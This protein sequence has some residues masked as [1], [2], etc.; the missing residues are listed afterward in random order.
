M[1]SK[2]K[3]YFY[4]KIG[5]YIQFYLG[6]GSSVV[7]LNPKNDK[8]KNF[9][10]P[11]YRFYNLGENQKPIE[12]GLII[13][14]GNLHYES[15]IQVLLENLHNYLN[16]KSRV[17][18]I[19]YSMLWKPFFQLASWLGF[20]EKTPQQNWISHDDLNTF[21]TLS[22][23]EMIRKDQR[24]LFPFYFP[25]LSEFIN[26]F[27]A[28]LPIFNWF[29]ILNVAIV[30]PLY[31][32]ETSFPKKPSVSIIVAARNEEG[33]IPNIARQIP[34]MGP[35]DEL[36]FVEGHSKDNTWGAI[37]ELEKTYT[38]LLNIKSAKQE[39]KGKGDAVRK[40]FYMASNEILMI[41][42]ADLTVAP[43]ELPKFYD[44]I[45]SGK[46]EYINGSRLVYPMETKAMRFM[47]MIGNKFFAMAF[48]FVLGQRFKDT[49]CGTKVMTKEN[50]LKLAEN[51]SYFGDFDPF[52]DFDLI[53]GATKLGLK[54]IEVPITYKQRTY[55]E[56]NISRWRHGVLL[57]AMLLFASR[58]IKFI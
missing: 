11:A 57:L 20:R 54:T 32:K 10:S 43:E 9:F 27:L 37:Q 52:G 4:N 40:G 31:S 58:K 26:R 14:N 44:A 15:D 53:F 13:L 45:L 35:K 7:E 8:L 2:V 19:Y 36:I 49:L 48:T 16:P 12:E 39:G 34:K 47:N 28:P 6:N 18:I 17:I 42:D 41:L 22:N 50:Y 1:K 56:T 51:R 25:I 46:A 33:N 30:R 55:G 23:F 21:L 38:G 29:C 5:H 3:N 24:I